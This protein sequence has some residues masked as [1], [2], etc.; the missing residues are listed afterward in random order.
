MRAVFLSI[1]VFFIVGC[2]SQNS[3]KSTLSD[4]EPPK[5]PSS[6]SAPPAPPSLED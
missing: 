3:S 4:A 6:I 1:I 5:A 2:E